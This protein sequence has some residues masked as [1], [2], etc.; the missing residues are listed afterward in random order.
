MRNSLNTGLRGHAQHLAQSNARTSMVHVSNERIFLEWLFQH[1][2][3][4]RFI[5]AHE[6]PKQAALCFTLVRALRDFRV[7][8]RY[9]RAILAIVGLSQFA[10][11]YCRRKTTSINIFIPRV[12][13]HPREKMILA[14]P[15]IFCIGFLYASNPPLQRNQRLLDEFAF[16][17]LFELGKSP[18]LKLYFFRE[19]QVSGPVWCG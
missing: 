4:P 11:K 12:A 17:F 5:A 6:S 8:L 2:R 18:G 15:G 7:Q 16:C 1:S 13:V 3:F 19:L 14:R 10:I 9:T